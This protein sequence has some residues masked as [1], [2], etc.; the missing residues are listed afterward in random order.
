[1]S[2]SSSLKQSLSCAAVAVGALTAA[3]PAAA[4]PIEESHY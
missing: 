1:M 2:L 3:A 4:D